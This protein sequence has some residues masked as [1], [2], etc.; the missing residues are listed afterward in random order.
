MA[1]KTKTYLPFISWFFIMLS[2]FNSS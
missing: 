2:L 1:T